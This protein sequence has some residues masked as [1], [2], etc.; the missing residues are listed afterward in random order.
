MQHTI[1]SR[2]DFS[3]AHVDLAAGETIVAEPGAMVGMSSNVQIETTGGGKGLLSS[4]KRMLGGESF[5]VNKYTAQGGQGRVSLAPGSPGDIVHIP[6]TPG[7]T[8]YVTSSCWLAS[9]PTITTDSKWGGVKGFLSGKGMILLKVDGS[10]DLFLSAYGA[11]HPVQVN[12]AY[13]VD[14]DHVVAYEGS[15]QYEIRKVG[16]LKSL[17]LGGEGLVCRYSGQ[18]RV[19]L[20]TRSPGSFASWIHPFR[21]VKAKN[22]G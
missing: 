14:T 6:V 17:F 20:Q 1:T 16:G 2:P 11:V 9:A 22:N 12:G 21:R 15:L 3:I 7:Q 10:G 8:W 4:M 13:T 19:F 5:F 18:G